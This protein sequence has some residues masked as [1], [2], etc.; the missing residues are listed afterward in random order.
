MLSCKEVRYIVAASLDGKLPWHK[1]LR[2][3]IPLS[4]CKACRLMARQ[5]E[6]LPAAARRYGSTEEKALPPGT[7]NTVRGGQAPA[8]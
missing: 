8:Y 4:M 1:R 3:R 5:M 7:G 6:L 2:V